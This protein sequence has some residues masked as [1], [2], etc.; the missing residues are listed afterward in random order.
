[1]GI[2][3]ADADM[4]R[5]FGT[6]IDDDAVRSL[7]L[8]TRLLGTKEIMIINHNDCGLTKFAD[9]ELEVRLRKVTGKSPIAP[10]K[11]YSFTDV[12]ENTKE[13]VRKAR[14]HPWISPDVP[15]RGFV[16]DIN[17]GRLGEVFPDEET[18]A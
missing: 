5:N 16:F 3:E 18:V 15:I 14:T 7:I 1:M 10:A 2:A 9:D 6:V 12:E 11:F 4:I 8:S 13:Q 17:T